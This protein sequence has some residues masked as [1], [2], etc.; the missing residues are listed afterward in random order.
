MLGDRTR[1]PLRQD[2]V[3]RGTMR[4]GR[5]PLSGKSRLQGPA[6]ERVS[7]VK[8]PIVATTTIRPWWAL[9][10][11]PLLLGLVGVLT[12]IRIWTY[13]KGSVDV[14]DIVL[15]VGRLCILAAYYAIFFIVIRQA[16]IQA[17]STEVVL[18]TDSVRMMREG[19]VMEE[20]PFNK[21]IWMDINLPED[22]L[23]GE[24]E[25]F[26]FGRGLV[27]I[28]FAVSREDTARMWPVVEA[29][30]W[31]HRMRLGEDIERLLVTK[32]D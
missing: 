2:G 7:T 6:P 31:K 24:I 30:A 14:E 15:S 5:R 17:L 20:I 3:D 16:A 19:R 21:T 11:L 9:I 28:H 10:W 18:D 4:G 32:G 12:V 25:G 8:G 22:G 1:G 26:S 29:A 13:P 27:N 23:V